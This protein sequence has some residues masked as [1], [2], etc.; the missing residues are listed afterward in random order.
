[1]KRLILLAAVATLGLGGT[2]TAQMT[3]QEQHVMPNGNVR[4][5]TTHEGPMGVQATT[6]VDRADGST[7]IVHRESE[8]RGDRDGMR[9]HDEGRRGD[10]GWHRGW[11]NHR[12][13]KVTW[14]HGERMRRCWNRR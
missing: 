13:C 10:R 7:R 1:M 9:M 6:R 4:T 5:T 8:W 3:T 2:A 11:R 12:V 14:H